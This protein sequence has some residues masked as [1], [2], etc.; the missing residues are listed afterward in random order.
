MVARTF[1]AAA[2]VAAVAATESGWPAGSSSYA[3]SS[4]A[5]SSSY[6]SG[7]APAYASYPASSSY[8]SASYS[9]YPA[10]TYGEPSVSSS[11]GP[12]P[13]A[14]GVPEFPACWGA[15][16]AKYQV[17][18]EDCLCTDSTGDVVASCISYGCDAVDAGSYFMWF[19]EYC[20]PLPPAE[21]TYPVP[22]YSYPAYTTPAT[23]PDPTWPATYTSAPAYESGCPA[24]VTTY[25]YRD[26][27]SV[28]AYPVDPTAPAGSWGA[29]G[30]ASPT[31]SGYVVPANS[32]YPV[33]PVVPA[34]GSASALKVSG[35][36]AGLVGLGALL[37]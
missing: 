29:S 18:S 8:Y 34:T 32:G 9:S 4:A 6:Y 19:E 10:P 11:Y 17:E 7:E 24:A 1:T 14:S 25:I 23:Y 26:S 31:G 5:P 13:S 28:G 22:T 20:A 33:D 36:L 21:N 30:Y 35:L 2:L 15:C 37:L 16:F 27:T 12:Y 3:P